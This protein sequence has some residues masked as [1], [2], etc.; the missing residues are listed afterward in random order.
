[1]CLHQYYCKKGVHSKA[2]HQSAFIAKVALSF[3]GRI[4]AWANE[5]NGPKDCAL[6]D[7]RLKRNIELNLKRHSYEVYE[8][9][10]RTLKIRAAV[11]QSPIS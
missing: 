11:N 1:M 5:I 2:P 7:T 4:D 6:R 3:Y 10:Y 9:K 8:F